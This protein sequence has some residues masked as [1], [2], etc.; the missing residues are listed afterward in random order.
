MKHMGTPSSFPAQA[1]AKVQMYSAMWGRGVTLQ[2]VLVLSLS[3]RKS[4]RLEDINNPSKSSL[5][6]P[7]LFHPF[8]PGLAEWWQCDP[9]K[10]K[11]MVV[12]QGSYLPWL[13]FLVVTTS[14]EPTAFKLLHD[15]LQ[16][17]GL[18][19]LWGKWPHKLQLGQGQEDLA[20]GVL[21]FLA[22]HEWCIEW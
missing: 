16:L 18:P 8:H 14:R 13:L 20:K 17:Q 6:N 22:C 2:S 12:G 4:T 1:A 15:F 21:W 3:S 9:G 10:D 7:P 5:Q 11:N 19:H